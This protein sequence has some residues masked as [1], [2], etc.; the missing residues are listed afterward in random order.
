MVH[1][2]RLAPRQGG[3]RRISRRLAPPRLTDWGAAR[4]VPS[5][6]AD[7]RE[8]TVAR[9]LLKV[10]SVNIAAAGGRRRMRPTPARADVLAKLALET[11][12][13]QRG[14]GAVRVRVRNRGSDA[15]STPG[16]FLVKG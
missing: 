11:L 10:S 2:D 4:A 14:R 5:A 8:P 13:N 6:A 1:H 9:V 3:E 15:R 12:R 16:S 7:P